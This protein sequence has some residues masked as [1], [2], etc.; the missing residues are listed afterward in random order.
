M[1]SAIYSLH[2]IKPDVQ[3][4][5]AP[6]GARESVVNAMHDRIAF[7]WPTWTSRLPPGR[8]LLGDELTVLDLYVTVVSRFALARAF[9]PGGAAHDTDGAARGR[10]ATAAGL[11]AGTL[12]T[13]LGRFRMVRTSAML[14]KPPLARDPHDQAIRRNRIAR[15][16]VCATTP[17]LVASPGGS[18]DGVDGP[19]IG[20]IGAPH[21]DWS[22]PPTRRW[23][24]KP[25][26]KA[27]TVTLLCPQ[28]CG[29]AASAAVSPD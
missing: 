10:G 12:P 13:R 27:A 22:K 5:G 28:L 26:G 17:A 4:I 24:R 14:T 6:P 23:W 1:S 15:S 19:R 9:L 25:N 16:H 3:R 29:R 18:N 11:L 2:W 7:C 20:D 8:Y 21:R